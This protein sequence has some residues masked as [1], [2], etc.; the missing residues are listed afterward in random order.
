MCARGRCAR[1]HTIAPS[2]AVRRRPL[3]KSAARVRVLVDLARAEACQMMGERQR[4]R[5]FAER[6]L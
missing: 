6:H 2:L 3:Y 1:A 5:A 4:A